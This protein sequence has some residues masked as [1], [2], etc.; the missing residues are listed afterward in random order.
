MSSNR[1]KK[2]QQSNFQVCRFC[3]HGN[4]E[5]LSSIYDKITDRVAVLSPMIKKVLT[6]L[7]IQVCFKITKI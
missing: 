1:I 5:D 2:L 6:L 3:L 7:D 4:T